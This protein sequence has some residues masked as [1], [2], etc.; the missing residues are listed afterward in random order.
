MIMIVVIG[1]GSGG[2]G[3]RVII[4]GAILHRPGPVALIMAQCLPRLERELFVGRVGD[5][6]VPGSGRSSGGS[7]AGNMEAHARYQLS[8]KRR[9]FVEDQ[10]EH[11][12][13]FFFFF[14]LSYFASRSCRRL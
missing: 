12:W 11:S 4:G 5:Q 7:T 6:G 10:D 3:V 9:S 1:P 14:S 13:R 8:K 2:G